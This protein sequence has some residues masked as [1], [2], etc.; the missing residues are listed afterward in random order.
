MGKFGKMGYESSHVC[1]NLH[2]GGA[3]SSHHRA[4]LPLG[5]YHAALPDTARF[6][7]R[8]K[9]L[10]DCSQPGLCHPNCTQRHQLLPLTRSELTRLSPS[11]ERAAYLQP[12]ESRSSARYPAPNSSCLWQIHFSLDA[13]LGCTGVSGGGRD[14]T[15]GK[16]RAYPNGPQ[17]PGSRLAQSQRLDYLPRPG[18]HTKK[19]RR[20]KPARVI[21]PPGG[22]GTTVG[23]G[24]T[25]IVPAWS[26]GG[27][28]ARRAIAATPSIGLVQRVRLVSAVRAERAAGPPLCSLA[29][30]ALV[31]PS[32]CL[33]SLQPLLS[34]SAP[35]LSPPE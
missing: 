6:L 9:T 32:P 2:R 35:S 29:A 26:R 33:R 20:A 24:G 16:H 21:T 12:G 28:Q 15:R 13:R 27:T 30:L 5:L 11:Q 23:R 3:A 17:A 10:R 4:A 7:Q 22:R 34:A 8:P 18:V 14:R 1:T 19:T 25:E 31:W